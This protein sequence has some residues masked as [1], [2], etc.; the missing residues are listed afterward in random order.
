MLDNHNNEEYWK[1]LIELQDDSKYINEI[2]PAYAFFYYAPKYLKSNFID[3]KK[4]EEDPPDFFIELKQA[5]L[6]NLEVTALLYETIPKI[7]KFFKKLEEIA[8]PLI[9][10]YKNL[11]PPRVYLVTPFIGKGY[12][13]DIKLEE[14]L[15]QA[16][17]KW[18]E[19]YAENG[20]KNCPIFN[21]SGDKIGRLTISN[22]SASKETKISLG[23]QGVHLYN[24]W[25]LKELEDKLQE[26]INKKENKYINK[27]DGLWW[28]LI[29]DRENRMNTT[30]LDFDLSNISL[31]AKFFKKIF[32]I[33]Y[34]N[35]VDELNVQF[36]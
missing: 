4:N 8:S 27:H 5:H 19:N 29:S 34:E 14:K 13:S 21:D 36:T 20:D 16:I 15:N 17:P 26:I 12:I 31:K 32:L 9:E 7:N 22:L 25:S 2:A 33:R 6:I 35:I 3:I 30:D 28:L 23:Q 18:F 24:N 11:L 10:K 1:R